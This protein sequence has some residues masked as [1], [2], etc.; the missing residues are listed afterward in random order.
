[1]KATSGA[2]PTS[3]RRFAWARR[4]RLTQGTAVGLVV[5][6]AMRPVLLDSTAARVSDS[7]HAVGLSSAE[8]CLPGPHDRLG[9]ISHLQL[10]EDV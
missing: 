1:M 4:T 7:A 9:A 10:C 3:C 6:R 2:Q 5:M 8:S